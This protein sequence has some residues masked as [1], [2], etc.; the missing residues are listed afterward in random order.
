MAQLVRDGMTPNPVALSA[1]ATL[2][3]VEA[4]L[5]IPDFAVGDVLGLDN[6]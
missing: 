4:A 2:L 6:G 3:E 1:T 5:A